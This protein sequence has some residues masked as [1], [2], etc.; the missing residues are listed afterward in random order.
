[1]GT[2]AV[3]D[4]Q[5]VSWLNEDEQR[6]AVEAAGTNQFEDYV[7]EGKYQSGSDSRRKKRQKKTAGM[8]AETY[9][10]KLLRL[11]ADY[12]KALAMVNM[13]NSKEMAEGEEQRKLERIQNI[14]TE[15]KK[16]G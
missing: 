5:L 12:E 7:L 16:L 13:V 4:A 3:R 15:I 6:D 10:E 14:M 2:I 1:M 9:T 8:L 11:E